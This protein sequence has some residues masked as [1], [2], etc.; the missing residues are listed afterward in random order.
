MVV[1]ADF[2]AGPGAPSRRL[3]PQAG[4][5]DSAVV[6][7]FPAGERTLQL[8]GIG[9]RQIDAILVDSAWRVHNHFILAVK[10][11]NIFPSDHFAILADL[12]LASPGR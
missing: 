9:L 6:G 8:Y 4:L 11:L 10:P 1:S 3:F 12:A 2:N 7:G 5:L